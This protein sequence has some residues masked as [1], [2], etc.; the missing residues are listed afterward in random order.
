VNLRSDVVE[1]CSNESNS[2]GK[3]RWNNQNG[4]IQ[5]SFVRLHD[6]IGCVI[7]M[8][9]LDQV[10]VVLFFFYFF[11]CVCVCFRNWPGCYREVNMKVWMFQDSLKIIA[12]GCNLPLTPPVVHRQ[13]MCF[14][15]HAFKL[16][17]RIHM[18]NRLPLFIT[19]IFD[20]LRDHKKPEA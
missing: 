11:G 5:T 7:S 8:R 18:K 17:T 1:H 2:N 20:I 10:C 12:T 19:N 16:W 15:I 6:R 9:I 3:G 13:H 4:M 14:T